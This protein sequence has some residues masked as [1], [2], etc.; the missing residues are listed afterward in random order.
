M[1][2]CVRFVLLQ[3]VKNFRAFTESQR[4]SSCSQKLATGLWDNSFQFTP[5]YS[6]YLLLFNMVC[7]STP[8]Y[9]KY[10]FS[11]FLTNILY[12]FTDFPHAWYISH[13]YHSRYLY[14][15]YHRNT[16]EHFRFVIFFLPFCYFLLL[17]SNIFL[18]ILNLCSFLRRKRSSFTPIRKTS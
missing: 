7:S 18:D 1:S 6:I 12:V 14:S 4:S 16:C 10:E 5:P 3:P 2:S 8:R 15:I 11:G 9:S 17:G 13:P